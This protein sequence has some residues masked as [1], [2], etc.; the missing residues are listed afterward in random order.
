[1]RDRQRERERERERE[2]YR[3][4]AR[5]TNREGDVYQLYNAMVVTTKSCFVI[6]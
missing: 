6:L 4:T 3:G 2:T 1:M 5:Q